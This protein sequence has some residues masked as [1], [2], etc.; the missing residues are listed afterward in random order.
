MAATQDGGLMGGTNLGR[1][2]QNARLRLA[3]VMVL[4]GLL[5]AVVLVQGEQPRWARAGIFLPFFMAVFT[6][7][8]GLL[9]TCPG[10]V[11]HG[12]ME[13]DNGHI[14]RVVRPEQIEKARRLSRIIWVGSCL[15]ALLST[16]AIVAIP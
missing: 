7:L 8:Q 1:S 13:D 4:A 15:V 11:M 3:S 10:H 14:E 16:L 5:M 9:R 12:T 2:G 6:A